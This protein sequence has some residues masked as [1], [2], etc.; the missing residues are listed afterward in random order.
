MLRKK[1]TGVALGSLLLAAPL[2]PANAA[3]IDTDIAFVIDESGSM[4]GEFQFLGSA[5]SEFLAALNDDSRIGTAQAGLISYL[6]EPTLVQDL[7]GDAD[8]L[9]TAFGSVS[10]GGGTENAL[11]AVDSAIPGGQ[12]DLGL[13]YRADTVKSVILITDEDADDDSPER[14]NELETLIDSEG[15]LVNIIADPFGDTYAEEFEQIARPA[16]ALFD[17]GAF[18]TAREEF[19][20]QFTN[21]KIQEITTD[22]GTD[23]AP[24]P[25]PPSMT[26]LATALLGLGLLGYRRRARG[27]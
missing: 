14:R 1:L 7:T 27:N 2:V 11:A 19:F 9:S 20:T 17:I 5:I 21:T 24:V 18:R 8:V 23:P 16:G 22:P 15:F 13:S 6:G 25:V 4:G 10:V 26:L 3:P 12:T